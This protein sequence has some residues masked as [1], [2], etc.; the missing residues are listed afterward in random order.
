MELPL[1]RS[2]TSS[3]I[4]LDYAGM[5][6]VVKHVVSAVADVLSSQSFGNPHSGGHSSQRAQSILSQG[7]ACILDFFGASPLEYYVVFTAGATAAVKLVGETFPWSSQSVFAYTLENH[8]SVVGLRALAAAA[9]ASTRV[10]DLDCSSFPLQLSPAPHSM[11]LFAFPGECNFSGDLYSL[12]LCQ[13][14][15]A[16]LLGAGKWFVLVDAAKLA[17][18]SP[19]S[20]ARPEHR[21]DFLTISFYKMFGYPTGIGALLVHRR[22][23]EVMRRNTTDARSRHYFGGGTVEALSATSMFVSMRHQL[24]ASLED[25][26]SNIHGILAVIHG[27]RFLSQV[28]MPSV[29]RHNSHLRVKLVSALA[30]MKYDQRRDFAIIHDAQHAQRMHKWAVGC[31]AIVSFTLL[32]ADGSCIGYTEVDTALRLANI[33]V[34]TGALCNIGAAQRYLGLTDDGIRS[35]LQLGHACWDGM[36]VIDGQ[37]TGVVRVSFGI[38]T[39]DSDIET[40]VQVLRQTFFIPHANAV[41]QARAGLNNAAETTP[42]RDAYVIKELCIYPVKSCAGQSVQGPWP[43]GPSGLA[44]DRS[45]ASLRVL[46]AVPQSCRSLQVLRRHRRERRHRSNEARAEAGYSERLRRP[47]R[48]CRAAVLRGLPARCHGHP[49]P[50][51]RRPASRRSSV[52]GGKYP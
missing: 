45:P 41:A 50:P 37:P 15:H 33:Q 28:G 6:P 24:A 31:G 27:L 39:T 23:A 26:S 19:I 13:D 10:V 8:T 22:A 34:R 21:P 32:K 42:P 2:E 35:H 14:V 4:Y 3:E 9:G 17:A 11:N 38:F 48:R 5:V 44:Y 30:D 29:A 46:S 51:R 1:K 47:C 16:G 52:F 20:L 25:G 7:R 36:D 43:L 18:G 12:E 40:L 49:S